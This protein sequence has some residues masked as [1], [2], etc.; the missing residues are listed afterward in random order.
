MNVSKLTFQS[1]IPI[2]YIIDKR[3]FLNEY[4]AVLIDANGRQLATKFDTIHKIVDSK[5]MTSCNSNNRILFTWPSLLDLTT[6]KYQLSKLKQSQRSTE[7][8]RIY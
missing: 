8:T 5:P 4:E 3:I 6:M 1:S 7:G 2:I